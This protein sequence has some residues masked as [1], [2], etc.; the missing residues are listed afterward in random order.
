MF[1]QTRDEN[2]KK[3]LA[4]FYCETISQRDKLIKGDIIKKMDLEY[5]TLSKYWEITIDYEF[6]AYQ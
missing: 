1:R 6:L 2:K 3:A 5:S 4:I